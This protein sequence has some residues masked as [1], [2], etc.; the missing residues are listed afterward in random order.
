MLNRGLSGYNTDWATLVFNEVS[1]FVL[2]SSRKDDYFISGELGSQHAPSKRGPHA[3]V[4]SP[5]IYDGCCQ[6]G[7][8]RAS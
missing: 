6:I 2:F 5:S 3:S 1:F 7:G 4:L 8:R